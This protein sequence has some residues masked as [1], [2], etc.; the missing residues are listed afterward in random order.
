MAPVLRISNG[1]YLARRSRLFET[2]A[3]KDVSAVVLFSANNVS[4]F[5]RF[6]FAQTE[7]PMW[8]VFTPNH[9]ALF[10]PRLEVEHA[11]EFAL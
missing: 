3:G 8:F 11:E 5:S 4:Y 9:S 2:L 10:V 6:A 7:R 1:E